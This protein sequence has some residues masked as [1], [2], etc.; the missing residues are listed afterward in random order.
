MARPKANLLKSAPKSKRKTRQQVANDMEFGQEPTWDNVKN[1]D[2]QMLTAYSYYA[3]AGNTK[4]AKDFVIDYIKD[5]PDY[6]ADCIKN[7]RAVPD[8]E[9]NRSTCYMSRMIALGARLEQKYVDRLHG[10]LDKMISLGE[11]IRKDRK[12]SEEPKISVHDRVK[13]QSNEIIAEFEYLRDYFWEKPRSFSLVISKRNPLS[14]LKEH[15]ASQAHARVVKKEYES[16]IAEIKLAI[17]GTDPDINEGYSCY[18]KKQL[19]NYSV[20]LQDIIDACDIVI[21]ESVQQ[22]K[23]RKKKPISVD[24]KVARVKYAV[25][26]PGVGLVGERPVNLV[27]ASVAFVYN[28]KTRKL[29]V[30]IA[31]DSSGLDV[32]GTKIINY[33]ETTSQAKTLRKP[34]E[35]LKCIG[36]A[37]TKSLKYFENEIKTTNISLN[38]SM[39][40]QIVIVK[41]FK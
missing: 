41:T 20:F 35:Q 18:T 10:Y 12:D 15:E 39:N 38:G 24:K 28:K 4:K 11:K 1:V 17:A 5:N 3:R 7:F 25:S 34:K 32:K 30:Y 36:N 21:G 16:V 40:D 2:R 13:E 22:R 23:P 29:G 8:I 27:G 9:I 37:R 6:T 19:T 14:I 33:N 31:D 26:D